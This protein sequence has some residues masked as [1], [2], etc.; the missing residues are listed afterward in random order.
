MSFDAGRSGQPASLEPFGSTFRRLDG[1]PLFAS[2]VPR[3]DPNATSGNAELLRQKNLEPIVGGIIHRRGA[4]AHLDTPGVN[5]R[6]F[7]PAR[8]RLHP[9]LEH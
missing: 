7:V 8:P 4:D 6:N 1:N 2:R 9:D 5:A 3:N